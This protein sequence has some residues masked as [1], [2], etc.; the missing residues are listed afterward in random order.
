MKPLN[1][2]EEKT[3][4]ESLN[5]RGPNNQVVVSIGPDS[6]Q[7]QSF[8]RL[9]PSIWLND[10]IIN[11]VCKHLVPD[12]LANVRHADR[13]TKPSHVMG[14]YLL[15]TYLQL[16]NIDPNLNGKPDY[17]AVKKWVDK[18]DVVDG[19]LFKLEYLHFPFNIGNYHWALVTVSFDSKKV[20]YFDSMHSKNAVI[21]NHVFEFI[22]EHYRDTYDNDLDI[23]HWK[24]VPLG[25]GNEFTTHYSLY[26][27]Q[28]NSK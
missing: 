20:V 11:L 14:T 6:I 9:G 18:I 27:F 26:P 5:Q 8:R 17:L 15:Q 10:K 23:T 28:Q 4:R 19:D 2:D 12:L 7:L 21:A 24:I 22:Q 16:K 25:T 13:G 1:E 3:I